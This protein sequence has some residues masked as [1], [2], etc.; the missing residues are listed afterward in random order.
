M[1]GDTGNWLM[2]QSIPPLAWIVPGVIPEGFG[3]LSAPPKMGK[4]WLVLDVGLSVAEGKPVFGTE[5]EQRPV[6]YLALEDGI[7]R[8]QD[9]CRTLG[10][11]HGSANWRFHL[12]P[13]TALGAAQSFAKE[14]P[15]ALV[16][17]DTLQLVKPDRGHGEA[18][19]AAD[20]KFTRDLKDRAP[21]HGTFLAVHHDRKAA[22]ADFLEEVSG[23]QG[24]AGAADFVMGLKRPR[25]KNEGMLHI[26]G[27]DVEEASYK[28]VFSDGRW[29]PEGGDL[30]EA[31]RRASEKQV[32]DEVAAIVAFVASR[33]ETSRADVAAKFAISPDA[34]AKRLQR[35][36]EDGL[37]VRLR[38]G[39]YGGVAVSSA[40]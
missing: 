6:M 11:T 2:R 17:V 4:S 38:P 15:N 27:R 24:I 22:S 1:R 7:R 33:S 32:S 14:H 40:A 20:Y 37:I 16:I 28:M 21:K 34:A 12:D 8:L 25:G 9:R 19:Y 5:V 10:I 39:A 30:G 3:I 18:S 36:C 26:T 31:A 23:T 29:T 35:L 13:P